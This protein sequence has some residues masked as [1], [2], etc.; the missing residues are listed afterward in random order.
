MKAVLTVGTRPNFIKIKP[1]L[2]NL[3]KLGVDCYLIQTGQ[4]YDR[5]LSTVFF[6]ELGIREP[7]F[8]LGIG[9]GTQAEQ[10]GNIMIALESVIDDI[11]PDVIVVVGDVNSTLAG[12]LVGAKA[13]IIVAHIESGLRSRDWYMPEEINRVVTDRVSDLLLAP[14]EEAVTNLQ[15]EGYRKDQIK[16]VGNVMI[17]TLLSNLDRAQARPILSEYN[18]IKNRYGLVTLHRPAN[19]DKPEQLHKV[20]N[21]LN[22][23]SE[24]IP[25]IFP[26]H[27][28]TKDKL[29]PFDLSKNIQT[30]EPLGYLDFIALQADAK[31]VLTDSGGVQ[32]ETTV[33]GV[34]CIT[35]RKTTE[36]P[37]TVLQGT[38]V[39]TGTDKSKVLET[40]EH[41][42]LSSSFKASKPD[43]WDG[44]A[45]ERCAQ[46][47]VERVSSKCNLRPTDLAT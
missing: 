40:I 31:V 19:V 28:R 11:K 20:V 9:S 27:P 42:L 38:N 32:E 21:I 1:V 25:L 23:V 46:A 4:H 12:A 17:D 35:L 15:S 8:D 5:K 33:L 45:G 2:E 24:R 44:N 22:E 10:T 37:I 36:R 47:I 39:V 3:E 29:L 41:I 18:L 16:L 43:L 7:D 6:Q 26:V 13:G 34:P 30:V 14:S